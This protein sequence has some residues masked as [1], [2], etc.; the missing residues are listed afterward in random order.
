MS[1]LANFKWYAEKVC[2]L[3]QRIVAVTVG[4]RIHRLTQKGAKEPLKK[5]LCFDLNKLPVFQNGTG[6]LQDVAMFKKY[7]DLVILSHVA[8]FS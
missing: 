2:S 3:A 8:N 4:E 1:A 5:Q 7:S 6:I